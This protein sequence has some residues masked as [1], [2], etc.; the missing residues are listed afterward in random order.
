MSLLTD[1]S[2]K[3]KAEKAAAHK[4]V[5]KITLAKEDIEL[6]VCSWDLDPTFTRYSYSGLVVEG[7]L[8]SD[9]ISLFYFYY[10]WPNS[11]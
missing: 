7:E 11:N 6:V 2:K 4:E 3:Q 9:C 8:E 5:E 10:R 1:V